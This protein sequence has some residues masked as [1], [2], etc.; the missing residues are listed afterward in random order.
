MEEFEEGARFCHHCGHPAVAGPLEGSALS[1]GSILAG[2][3]IVGRVLGTGGFGITYLGHD[4][5]L[6]RK[7]A[8]KEYFPSDFAKRAHESTRLSVFSGDAAGYFKRG[9]ASFLDEARRLAA[10]ARQGNIVAVHDTLE[11]NNTAYIVMEYL[12]GR[13]LKEWLKEKG[14]LG[15]TEAMSVITPVLDALVTVHGAGIIHR[16]VAPDNIFI[17]ADD[18]VVL[19]DFGAARAFAKDVNRSMT[20]VLKPGYAPTEQYLSKGSQGPWTDVYATAATLYRMLTGVVPEES[21][22]RALRDSL[23]P[24]SGLGVAIPPTAEAALMAALAVKPEQRIWDVTT[25]KAGLSGGP[26]QAAWQP[27]PVTVVGWAAPTVSAAP[28]AASGL[29]VPTAVPVIAL[30][31]PTPHRQ[32]GTAPPAGRKKPKALPENQGVPASY[33]QKS[34]LVAGLLSI[35]FGG[36]GVGRFYLG[37]TGIGF[38]QIAASF[39][40]FGLSSWWGVVEGIM[41]LVGSIAVDKNG[42]PLRGRSPQ[43][44]GQ[45]SPVTVVGWAA[46]VAA[47][48]PAP[49]VPVVSAVASGWAVPTTES[50][51]APTF[52]PTVTPVGR[53]QSKALTIVLVTILGIFIMFITAAM[54]YGALKRSDS[55]T[56]PSNSG[57]VAANDQVELPSIESV[58]QRVEFGTWRGEP[59][60]WRVLAIDDDKVLVVSEDSLALR[61]Y[62]DLGLSSGDDFNRDTAS[63]TWAES[64]IRAWL[65]GEFLDTAFT[66]GEQRAINLSKLSNPDNPGYGTEGGADTED[67][68]FLLSIDEANRYF[69]GDSDRIA[70][71]TMTEEDIQYGLRIDK[72]SGL[73]Q[74]TISANENLMRSIYLGQSGTFSW[75]LRSPGINACEAVNVYNDGGIISFNG[76][77]YFGRGVRPA[78]WLNL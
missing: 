31:A 55:S 20:V 45:P 12:E 2:R 24:P 33:A 58:G 42:I 25:F 4:G 34:K 77:A 39:F 48:A 32:V 66:V 28:A 16:D 17:R 73:S 49:T 23:V 70:N 13:T 54:I 62:D 46:P 27:G 74:E 18:S 60:T 21:I 5:A 63:I 29:A 10:F 64:D 75:W 57:T 59:I 50:V 67:K 19:I 61:Q 68:V 43:A 11:A 7:V 37:Y 6:G 69:S 41:I 38:A 14:R 40:T 9:L 47:Q 53:E 1:E 44:A 8:V 65:N 26:P 35:F 22:Q 51:I 52:S 36:L 71:I 56:P 76:N 30:P 72:V 78:L 3:Y 15:F